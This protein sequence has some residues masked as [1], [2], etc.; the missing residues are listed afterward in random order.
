MFEDAGIETF[1]ENCSRRIKIAQAYCLNY[2]HT[3]PEFSITFET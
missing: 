3:L 2:P 1:P